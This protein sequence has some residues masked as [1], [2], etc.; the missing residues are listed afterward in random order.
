MVALLVW[1]QPE[2]F[3]SD[4]LDHGPFLPGALSGII[5]QSP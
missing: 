5:S 4:A 2:R 3:D 1:D